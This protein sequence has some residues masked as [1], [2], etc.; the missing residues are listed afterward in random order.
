MS[1]VAVDVNCGDKVARATGTLLL[2]NVPIPGSVIHRQ[3][4]VRRG[5]LINEAEVS[6][7]MYKRCPAPPCWPFLT[8]DVSQSL[9]GRTYRSCPTVGR[10][11]VTVI[12]VGRSEAGVIAG[13]E[14]EPAARWLA[15]RHERGVRRRCRDRVIETGI[16]EIKNIHDVSS[17]VVWCNVFYGWMQ[18]E[19]TDVHRLNRV[20]IR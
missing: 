19:R 11:T 18:L 9:S 3:Q 7:A 8:A 14:R 6:N 2:V 4:R 13:G 10:R 12:V 20:G 5:R 17:L 1:R 15:D 16:V